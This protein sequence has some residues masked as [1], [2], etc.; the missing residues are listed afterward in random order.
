VATWTLACGVA[1][2]TPEHVT[3]QFWEALRSDDLARARALATA[4][5]ARRVAGLWDAGPIE[6]ILLGEALRGETSAIVKTSLATASDD[7][8][9]HLSFDTSLVRVN[10]G[11]K[12]DAA[13]THRALTGALFAS[14]VQDLGDAL[15]E[16]VAQFG[17]AIE[18][19]AEDISRAI[20]EAIEELERDPLSDPGPP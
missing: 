19:G 20:R 9:R 15:G 2:E 13:E 16:G 6:E 4:D 18:S 10:R 14:S 12:V 8:T 1:P 3:R 5:S 17:E 7:G 11:W